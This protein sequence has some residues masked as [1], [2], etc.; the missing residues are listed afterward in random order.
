MHK[1][2]INNITKKF[3]GLVAVENIDMYIDNNEIIGLIGPN[4]AGKTTLFNLLT[5]MYTPTTGEV[6]YEGN[7][8]TGLKPYT[9]TKCGLA[10]TFQN[11]R[12]FGKM[13]V[14]E[15]VLVGLHSRCKSNT[16][17][18]ILRTKRHKIEE[19]EN[20]KKA[21]EI[22]EM[23][24][25]KN[26]SE[27]LS[28]NLPYGEQ[29][30]LEIARALASN[31]GILLLDEPAAGMNENETEELKKFIKR[32]KRLGNTVLLIE[33]DMK[34]VMNICERIYVID[35]GRKIAEGFPKDIQCNEKVI[36]AY[37]GKGV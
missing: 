35:H 26:K 3:G 10:R 19:K 11:I 29:R 6:I 18:A 27:E 8:I 5:G 17:D 20:I 24:D 4:G 31:P 34:L 12:L 28:K 15:N 37:L 33:H 22:L 32:L 13:T 2:E 30:K 21:L 23:V 9:I 36:E 7:H 25:L 1:L 16:F 14:I